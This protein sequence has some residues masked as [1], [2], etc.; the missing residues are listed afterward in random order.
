MLDFFDD[1]DFFDED[2]FEDDFFDEVLFRDAEDFFELEAPF[3]DED[4]FFDEEEAFFD[5]EAFFD[6]PPFFDDD[7][8]DGTFPPSARAS[9]SPMAMACLR[10][11]TVLPEPPLFNSPRFISCIARS[12]F[13]PDFFP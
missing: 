13:S 3:F 4:D 8:R 2:F 1:E 12:T 7:L 11:F 10:L 9:D 5:D 6:E